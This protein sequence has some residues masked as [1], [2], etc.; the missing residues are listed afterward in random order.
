MTKARVAFFDFTCCEG[1]QLDVLNIEGED[2]VRLL[3]AVDIV[4]FREV[5][6]GAADEYDIAFVE[7]SISRESEIPRL[8]AIRAALRCKSTVPK[9]RRKRHMYRPQIVRVLTRRIVSCPTETEK[10][11]L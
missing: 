10:R 6:S 11:F 1:C 4:E 2:L 5:K 3:E 7:R 8:K 9:D